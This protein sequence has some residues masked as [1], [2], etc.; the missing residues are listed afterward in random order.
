M[1]SEIT[2]DIVRFFQAEIPTDWF[3]GGPYDRPTEFDS[4]DGIE[5]LK[6]DLTNPYK[7][8][9]SVDQRPPQTLPED[10]IPMKKRLAILS[11]KSV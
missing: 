3:I 6:S 1:H 5:I 10:L 7:P 8:Y 9:I 4:T 11:S 2:L